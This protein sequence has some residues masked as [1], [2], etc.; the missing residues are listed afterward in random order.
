MKR[1]VASFAEAPEAT[2]DGMPPMYQWS[3]NIFADS[4]G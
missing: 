1:V 2:T 4:F 3:D